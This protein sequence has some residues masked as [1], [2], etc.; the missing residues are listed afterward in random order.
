MSTI[1]ELALDRIKKI[2]AIAGLPKESWDDLNKVIEKEKPVFSDK[3][4][5]GA[6]R[7]QIEIL[8]K[9]IAEKHSSSTKSESQIILENA[10]SLFLNS[11]KLFLI[12]A[13]SH[14]FDFNFIWFGGDLPENRANVISAWREKHPR[15][16]INLW[17]HGDFLNKPAEDLQKLKAYAKDKK[18]NLFDAKQIELP[19]YIKSFLAD[20]ARY[21]GTGPYVNYGLVSDIWRLVILSYLINNS[22]FNKLKQRIYA[23]SDISPTDKKLPKSF[24]MENGILINC[25]FRQSKNTILLLQKAGLSFIGNDLI[26]IEDKNIIGESLKDLEN[27]CSNLEG[28]KWRLEKE[29]SGWAESMIKH[30]LYTTG[31]KFWEKFLENKKVYDSDSTK[32]NNGYGFNPDYFNTSE[33]GSS[34]FESKTRELKKKPYDN[35]D[36]LIKDLVGKIQFEINYISKD[37]IFLKGYMQGIGK[38]FSHLFIDKKELLSFYEKLI[39]AL[40]DAFKKDK[41]FIKMLQNSRDEARDNLIS[42]YD[43]VSMNE[44][45]K[46]DSVSL[47][48][49]VNNK[50]KESKQ[51]VQQ[52]ES[53]EFLEQASSGE[54]RRNSQEF[55]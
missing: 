54:V 7:K 48:V 5:I 6:F 20:Y 55:L 30:T 27:N 3:A 16:E 10:N 15:L 40:E 47:E 32:L 33:T 37:K 18:I 26:G 12:A 53:K 52:N 34:W 2:Q 45:Q 8:E 50:L 35:Y 36:S 31:P 23:D 19:K 9:S 38:D 24:P 21:W 17:Y 44:Q 51:K 25:Y 29:F 4:I 13:N 14:D 39:T 46:R 43:K 11:C 41:K 1:R 42:S 22:K 28:E 49:L